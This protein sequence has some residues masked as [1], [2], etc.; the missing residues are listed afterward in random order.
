MSHP[1]HFAT[2]INSPETKIIARLKDV[3]SFK[4][5]HTHRHT[6]ETDS[7]A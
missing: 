4:T 5:T 3:G 1:A 6:Y 7:N 2:L